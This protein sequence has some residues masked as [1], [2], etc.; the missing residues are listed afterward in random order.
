M[1]IK[2][3]GDKIIASCLKGFYP[4]FGLFKH[5]DHN[6]RNKPCLF[7]GAYFLQHFEA[8]HPRHHYV[9]QNQIDLTTGK[10][11]QRF[12][13]A[14][15]YDNFIALRNKMCFEKFS[16]FGLVIDC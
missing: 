13:T 11:F 15:R 6:Y 10:Y 1:P 8:G 7:I 16:V 2:R 9:Q 4:V 12:F 5:R 3:L 14:C